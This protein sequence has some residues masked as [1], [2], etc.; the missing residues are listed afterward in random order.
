MVIDFS[1]RQIKLDAPLFY[2]SAPFPK[3]EDPEL[4][5]PVR[6]SAPIS[7]FSVWTQPPPKLSEVFSISKLTLL[8]CILDMYYS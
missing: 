1:A 7:P 4:V 3:P 6:R 2:I 8:L 5:F